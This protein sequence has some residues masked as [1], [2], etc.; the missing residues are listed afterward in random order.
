MRSWSRRNLAARLYHWATRVYPAPF[1]EEYGRELEASFRDQIA[2]AHGADRARLT[3]GAAAD[4]LATAPRVHLDLLRQ[5]LRYAWRALTARSQRSFAVAAILT[6]A[7]GVGA[8]TAI[9]SVVYAVMLAPLPYHEADRVVRIYETNPSR[10]INEFSVSVPNLASWE[11]QITKMTLAAFKDAA[12]NLTDGAEAAHVNGLAATADTF[13]VLGLQLV[14]G[15][16]FTA[17]ED[18]PG[19]P[20]AAIVSEGLWQRRYAGREDLLGTPIAV[21]GVAHTIVGIAPQDVGFSRDVDLWV[22]LAADVANEGRGDKRLAVVGRLKAGATLAEGH[23]ELAAVAGA[24]AREFPVDNGGWSARLEPVFDW[25]VGGELPQRMR[26]LVIA[27][28]LLLLVACA[29]V[30][31]L[32][33]ARAAG[34]TGELGVRLALGAN[35]ARLLRQTLTESLVL[36]AAGAAAGLALAWALVSGSKGVLPASIPRLA[37]LSINLPV[38]AA[39]LLS[40]LAVALVSGLLPTLMAGRADIRDALQH[41]GRPAAIGARAPIRH[42]LVGIQLALSTSLVVGA[43]LLLQST[44]NMQ[45]QGLGI[46]EPE[47]LL[48]ANITRPQGP[49]WREKELE[50]DLAFYDDV[51]REASALPGVVSAGLSSGLPLAYGNTAMNVSSR[52]APKGEA[53]GG[54]QAS[55]RVVSSSY[56]KTLDVPLLR[57]RIFDR[58]ADTNPP[59]VI[60]R[61]LAK[62]LWPQGDDPVGRPLYLGGGDSLTIVG[63]VGDVRLT[64]IVR[65][66]V[67]AIYIPPWLTM[68]PTMTVVIRAT[69]DP[70]LLASSL[71]AAV[72]RVDRAQPMFDVETMS[73]IVGRRLAEPRLNAT[74]LSIFAGLALALAAVGVAGVMAYAVAR[75]T[76]ELAI[77]QALGASPR[78]AM[79]VVLAAGLKVCVAGIAMGLAGALAL[80]QSLAGL[81]YGV[82][83]RDLTTLMTTSLALAAVAAVACWLPARRATRISPTLALREQ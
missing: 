14:R 28:G 6:L 45:A 58:T 39:A 68:W 66:P 54:I 79:R 32:Q 2:D 61:T 43:A 56:F 82:A 9:F 35:R 38:L 27:V 46:G 48:T 33:M 78:Q 24:L 26:L 76:G 81:L 1:R 18:R 15:R 30:A 36:A 47:R 17:A 53:L 60:S 7:L 50:R 49:D 72:A 20:K 3:A 51:L 65:E 77:R 21:D 8:A 5:D 80:G 37:D 25:I 67:P 10:N 63:V 52:P 29:N 44:W 57:G 11:E 19:G 4:V 59:V 74:L 69:G 34:R 22:P 75:R 83:P 41:A 70:A 42:A 73:T 64:S 16:A 31:N 12:A 71:R 62:R 13:Q 55:W 40:T 23:A